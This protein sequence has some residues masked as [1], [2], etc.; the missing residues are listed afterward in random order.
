MA[1]KILVMGLPGSGKTYF[2]G[3]LKKYIEDNSSLSTMP[4]HMMANMEGVSPGRKSTVDWFNAD[5]VRKRFNDWDFT[6]EGR[7]RQSLRMAEFAMKC[8]GDYVI[9][10]FVAPLPEMRE[11]FSAD[12]IVWMDTIDSGRYEDTNKAFVPPKNYDFRITEKNAEEWVKFVGDH[13]LTNTRRPT[14]DPRKETVQ[15]LG[16]W[17]PWHQGHRA[18]FERLLERTGQVCIMVRDCQGWNSSNPFDFEHVK[19]L[20]HRDLDP[21]HQGKFTVI[22]VPNIVHIGYGRGVGY[23]IEEEKFDSSIEEISGTNIRL[24]MGLK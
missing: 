1:I 22:L 20:I 23:T 5:Q 16:R 13:I 9:C 14:F 6:R 17:Q 21:L 3:L 8:T 2:S 15:Q 4:P 7:I 19:N 24:S 12:W 10:D 18:L 11:N